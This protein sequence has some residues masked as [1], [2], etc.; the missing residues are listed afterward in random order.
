MTH[1]INAELVIDSSCRLG[2]GPVWNEEGQ[3][4]SWVDIELNHFY[5]YWPVDGRSTRMMT[6]VTIGCYGWRKSGGLIV[7]GS[8]GI[9]IWDVEQNVYSTIA[10][11][12]H[13]QPYTRFN[14]GKCDPAGRFVAGTLS[15]REQ[16][17]GALY[18]LDHDLNVRKL[19]DGISCSNG[20][21]WSA[22]GTVMYYIDS[23]A[24]EVVS[25]DYDLGTGMLANPRT[26]VSYKGTDILP[27]GM[28]IDSEGML[29]VAEWGGWAVTRWNPASGEKLATV[30]VPSQY[31]TSCA[32][33][34]ENSDT[35][36]IT[37]ARQ[38]IEGEALQQQPHS[39]G[40]FVAQAGVTGSRSYSFG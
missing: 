1:I 2:E 23:M 16:P 18:V 4:I 17:E 22:D 33:A 5:Q 13:D 35:L 39:G 20:I 24:Q 6:P 32:F 3:Y 9:G 19:L 7:A 31:V 34:G 36:F 38:D 40:L 26:V 8:E 10:D 12:E 29:W 27:D 37:T 15:T 28:T 14:D 21:S 11:P 25:Y 30:K